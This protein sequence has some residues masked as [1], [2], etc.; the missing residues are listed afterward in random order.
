MSKDAAYHHG[1]LRAALLRAAAA[2]IERGGYENLS[3]REL[4]ATLEVSRA[5]PYRHFADR[6][7]L[8]AALAAD[9]FD[10]LTAIYRG[11][12]ASRKAPALRLADA[13]RAYLAFATDRPQLFR[14]MFA[15]DLF[16]SG[17]ADSRLIKTAGDCYQVFESLVA[18]TLDNPGESAVKAAAIAIMSSTY[19]F[20]LLL[21][22]DRLR[23]F[24]YGK[25][26]RG[27]LIEA[28]LSMQVGN[29]PGSG[30]RHRRRKA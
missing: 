22:G 20:A 8:L 23:P 29:L 16:S 21:T 11:V 17:A 7:A 12:M 25:V 14:L 13:G 2:E 30:R 24:M 6:Q 5:A 1:H 15:S 3:L 18:A 10:D 26:A 28:V 27:E 9:G 4:S 19:G